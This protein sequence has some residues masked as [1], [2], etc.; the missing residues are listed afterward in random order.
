MRILKFDDELAFAKEYPHLVKTII[1]PNKRLIF[2]SLDMGW[3]LVGVRVIEGTEEE[4][5]DIAEDS[6]I[7]QP[8]QPEKVEAKP[9]IP[10]FLRKDT[11]EV[12]AEEE[13]TIGEMLHITDTPTQAAT[14][15][16]PSIPRLPGESDRQYATRK[17]LE[18]KIKKMKD[19]ALRAA[20]EGRVV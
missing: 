7:E 14:L 6:P 8:K 4:G 5:D 9:E 11:L 1:K 16:D 19:D 12:S 2:A 18:Q 3:P 13:K 20:S 10:T 17:D 15:E